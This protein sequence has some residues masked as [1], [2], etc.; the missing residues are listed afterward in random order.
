MASL[1]A[2]EASI[3]GCFAAIGP[4]LQD[5]VAASR[6]EPAMSVQG[7]KQRGIAISKNCVVF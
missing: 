4:R 3:E 6:K 1:P 7:I 2:L 5:V